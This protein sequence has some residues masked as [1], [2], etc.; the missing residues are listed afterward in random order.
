MEAFQDYNSDIT[1]KNKPVRIRVFLFITGFL[2]ICQNYIIANFFES[3]SLNHN[4]GVIAYLGFIMM[5]FIT[6]GTFFILFNK[7]AKLVEFII[8][9]FVVL[10]VIVFSIALFAKHWNHGR[11]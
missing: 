1:K 11:P 9:L 7:K 6:L 2:M 10:F 4:S 3:Q 8:Y 5:C